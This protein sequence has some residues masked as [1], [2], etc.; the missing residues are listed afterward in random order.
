MHR[1]Y[2]IFLIIVIMCIIIVIVIMCQ[3]NN[4]RN[5]YIHTTYYC[6]VLDTFLLIMGTTI[7]VHV[8]KRDRETPGYFGNACSIQYKSWSGVIS[9]LS[10]APSGHLISSWFIKNGYRCSPIFPAQSKSIMN[11]F[12]NG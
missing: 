10:F 12:G 2:S 1:N 11:S 3:Y 8:R 7:I 5:C 9:S 4:R 6:N